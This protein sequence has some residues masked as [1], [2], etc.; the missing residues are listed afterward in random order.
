MAQLIIFR[1]KSM[2]GMAGMMDCYVNGQV[3]CRIRNGEEVSCE[4][5]NAIV[6]FSCNMYN[7]PM[8]DEVYLDLADGKTVRVAVKQ[9]AIKP[10]VKV[11]DRSA[12]TAGHP[13][14][15]A[16]PAK[17][18]CTD[19]RS[20][21]RTELSNAKKGINN[22]KGIEHTL[23]LGEEVLFQPT[24]EI[25]GYFAVDENARL[26]AV[27]KGLVPTLKNATPRKYEDIVA[28]ELLEDGGSVI[29]GSAGRALVGAMIWGLGGAIIGA[30]GS[31]KVKPTCDSLMIKITINS[32]D[33]P[34]EYIKFISSST[35]KSG[36]IYKNACR[37]AQEIVSLLQIIT[38]CPNTVSDVAEQQ[39]TTSISV[40]AAD[41]I[42]KYKKLMDEGIISREEFEAKKKQLL[43]V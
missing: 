10:T 9:G 30:A 42:R 37:D 32:M 41:E 24:K 29:K 23:Q 40:S 6:S 27:G 36:M 4:V 17:K 18:E 5:A 20:A 8:S 26:W 34:V 25:G 15:C 22:I 21:L 12:V 28:F 16:T 43:G 7:N 31:R 14:T 19:I 33:A 38:N 13:K 39:G 3:V 2:L 1:E 11:E 35:K